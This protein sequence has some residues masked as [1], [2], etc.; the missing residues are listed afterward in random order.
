[1]MLLEI[2]S[3]ELATLRVALSHFSEYLKED[4]LGEDDHGKEMVRLYQQNI[5]SLLKKIIQK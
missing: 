2:D 1:M 5:N 3:N 4:G